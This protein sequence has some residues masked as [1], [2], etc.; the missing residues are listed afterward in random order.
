MQ[1]AILV[2]GAGRRVGHALALHLRAQ[3]HPVIGHYHHDNPELDA[4]RS[5][6]ITVI[7][8]DFTDQASVQ[9][10]AELVKAQCR[11]LRAII[12]NASAFS[13]TMTAN[14][15]ALAQFDQFYQVHMRSPF[16]LTRALTGHLRACSKAHADIIHISDIFAD[17]PNPRFDSYCASKAGG[18][19]LALSF[20]QSLAPKIKVNVIQPGP[21]LF[22]DWHSA[23]MK[24]KVLSETLL[25]V[26]GG[27]EPICL[28]VSALLA[29]PYQTGAVIA[30]DG[31]RRLG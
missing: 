12:H 28:A 24:E 22:K 9:A 31:G 8:A 3:G 19:N 15:D 10:L 23:E 27:A 6:G 5:A 21:I 13:A 26:E 2:T 11:S 29:N 4:L 1:D 14:D 16:A 25:G 18:Q 7:R 30:V 17:K 20:A